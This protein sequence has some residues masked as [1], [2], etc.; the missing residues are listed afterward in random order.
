MLDRAANESGREDIRWTDRED[1]RGWTTLQ[2][3][4]TETRTARGPD[5][6]IIVCAQ[7]NDATRRDATRHDAH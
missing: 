3:S 4:T 7:R 6:H 5:S 1:S 2:I